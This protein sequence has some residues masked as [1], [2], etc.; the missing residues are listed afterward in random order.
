MNNRRTTV[1]FTESTEP[2]VAQLEQS[3]FDVRA[4]INGALIVFNQLPGDAQKRAI[5]IANGT[6]DKGFVV[7]VVTGETQLARA[8][9]MLRDMAQEIGDEERQKIKGNMRKK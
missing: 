8:V 2:L 4:I 3:G 1:E 7:E 5:A 6:D 9:K